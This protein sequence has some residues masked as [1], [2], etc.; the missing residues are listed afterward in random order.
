MLDAIGSVS[1][2]AQS[3][4]PPAPAQTVKTEA[5]VAKATVQT[6]R[7]ALIEIVTDDGDKVTISASAVRAAS[8]A[9]AAGRSETPEGTAA[10]AGTAYSTTSSRSLEISVEGT[11][12]KDELSDIRRLLTMLDRGAR[13]SDRGEHG[14]GRHRGHDTEKHVEQAK[15][16]SL[17][18]FTATFKT[19]TTYAAT[20]AY[21]AV[22][23]TPTAATA[24]AATTTEP[25]APPM[26]P[27]TGTAG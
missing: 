3:Y 25:E 22:T 19:S 9:A 18:S 17:E 21:T 5:A 15:L 12:D 13:Q 6:T 1:S 20:A 23:T 7:S 26:V 16:D 11:L 8:V 14:R 4:V 2:A 24:P 27:A 10:V